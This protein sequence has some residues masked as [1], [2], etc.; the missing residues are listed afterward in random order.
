MWQDWSAKLYSTFTEVGNGV[1]GFVPKLFVSLIVF[2][3]GWIIGSVLGNLVERFFKSI[4]F[5]KF[6]DGLGLKELLS[7]ADVKLNSGYF[8]GECVKWFTIVVF[9][10]AGL[11]VLGLDAVNGVLS[12][13]VNV[14]LP[15]IIAAALILLFGGLIANASRSTVVASAKAMGLPSAHFVGGVVRW[16]IWVLVIISA[17]FQFDIFSALVQTLFTGVVAALALAIG[18]SFGLGGKEAA[19]EYL[20]KLRRDINE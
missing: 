6:L 7:H 20:K 14:Y 4:D 3:A 19:A 15:H 12:G 11:N 8:L 13:L 17:L 5:D 2:I 9:L 16:T 18:L 1:I 10:F